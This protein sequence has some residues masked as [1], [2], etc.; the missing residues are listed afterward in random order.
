M[1]N[2]PMDENPKISSVTESLLLE[3]FS[4][5]INRGIFNKEISG[6]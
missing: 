3:I 5:F 4:G 1:E 6:I 2:R